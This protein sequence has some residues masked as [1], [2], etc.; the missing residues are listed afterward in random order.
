MDCRSPQKHSKENS[1]DERKEEEEQEKEETSEETKREK[2]RAGEN[3]RVQTVCA[4][5]GPQ[6]YL[7]AGSPSA[8][9][10]VIAI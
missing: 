10:L 7:I 5:H 6:F 8:I 1:S 9:L 2:R 3:I 4:A